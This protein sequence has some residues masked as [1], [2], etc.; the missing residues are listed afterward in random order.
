M[1]KNHLP[2]F[3]LTVHGVNQCWT[4]LYVRAWYKHWYQVGYHIPYPI[5]IKGDNIVA[6]TCASWAGD[7]YEYTN[8]KEGFR[9]QY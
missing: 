1:E 4:S 7:I 9:M 6:Y 5:G 2:W 3:D 8:T